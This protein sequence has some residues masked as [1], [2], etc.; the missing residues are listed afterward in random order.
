MNHK[1]FEE[2]I[3]DL[4]LYKENHGHLNVRQIEDKSLALFCS[5]IRRSRKNPGDVGIFKLNEDRIASLDALGFGWRT[6]AKYL[7]KK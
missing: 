7:L 1:S 4:V 2:R 6:N 3:A 5:N